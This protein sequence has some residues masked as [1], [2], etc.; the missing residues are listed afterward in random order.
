LPKVATAIRPAS[1]MTEMTSVLCETP[2]RRVSCSRPKTMPPSGV[3]NAAAMPAAAPATIRSCTSTPDLG[4]RKRFAPAMMPAPT[5]TVGPSRPIDK[6][7]SNPPDTS[8]TLCSATRGEA[9]QWRCSG[10][11]ESSSIAR[12]TCGMPEPSA[13]G[14]KRRVQASTPTVSSGVQTSIRNGAKAA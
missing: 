8:T 10:V 7:A 1:T 6:P 9:S 3:L 14:S 12:T 11:S 4:E 13:A 5:C 2:R